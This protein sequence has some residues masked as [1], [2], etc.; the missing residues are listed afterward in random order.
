MSIFDYL[1]G[2]FARWD[3]LTG[4]DNLRS[5]EHL[6]EYYN[7]TNKTFHKLKFMKFVR[8]L[9]QK[10]AGTCENY[11]LPTDEYTKAYV[12]LCGLK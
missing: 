8:E 6:Q 10:D 4:E 2:G 7:R 11:G 9:A 12:Q 1:E 3:A 5:R